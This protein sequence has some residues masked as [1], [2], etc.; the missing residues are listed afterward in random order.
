MFDI[1]MKSKVTLEERK[2]TNLT[3]PVFSNF[4]D[5]LGV[6]D[7]TRPTAEQIQDNFRGLFSRLIW[8]R[9]TFIANSITKEFR[10]IR[11]IAQDEAQDVDFSHPWVTLIQNPNNSRSA[12]EVWLWAALTKDLQGSAEFI[13][14]RNSAGI[15]IAIHEVFPEFGIM[16]PRSTEDGGVAGYVYER[17]DGRKFDFDANDVISFRHVDPVSPFQSSSL[18]EKAAFELDKQR[19][20]NK[21][22]RDTLKEGRFPNVVLTTD[23]PIIAE[24]AAEQ[25]KQFQ[26]RYMRAGQHTV[27][28][29][30]ILGAGLQPRRVSLNPADLELIESRKLTREDIFA[31]CGVPEG[32]LSQKANRANSEAAQRVFAQFT[33][34][35]EVDV[36]A[37]QMSHAFSNVFASEDNSLSIESP[38]V[39]PV[40]KIQ[41]A[42]IDSAMI[43]NGTLTVNDVRRREGLEE[44]EFGDEALISMSLVTLKSITDTIDL[45]DE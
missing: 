14:E 32:L 3:S 1:F 20:A 28:G 34:Q 41:Q 40:D 36:F 7:S 37:S 25:S 30:P 16:R 27:N 18:I 35:P 8:L 22:E 12:L 45:S 38:N 24:M 33:M 21:Y 19:Y 43:T 39:V 5:S 26:D 11:K 6:T 2:H 31:V 29:V 4:A 42:E 9:A 44:V 17:A 10:V 15:P 23:Q 13:V